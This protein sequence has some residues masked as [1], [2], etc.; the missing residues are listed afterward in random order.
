MRS[1]QLQLK[2]AGSL[3]ADMFM[4]V[5]HVST[6]RCTDLSCWVCLSIHPRHWKRIY[7][8]F[9]CLQLCNDY[10]LLI[11]CQLIFLSTV[12]ATAARCVVLYQPGLF[13]MKRQQT[14]RWSTS[15][16]TTWETIYEVKVKLSGSLFACIQTGR[17]GACLLRVLKK[18]I[19]NSCA[20][21]HT[22]LCW[23]C[24]RAY[25]G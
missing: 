22:N 5:S 8:Y 7:L 20:M 6:T 1:V 15:T 24:V 13:D 10:H 9:K 17:H 21:K 18:Q 19:E 16:R 3:E 25:L 12:Q 11:S 23:W 2:N 4:L 14:H